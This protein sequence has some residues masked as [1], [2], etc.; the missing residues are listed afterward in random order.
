VRSTN[1]GGTDYHDIETLADIV[2]AYTGADRNL[3]RYDEDQEVLTTRSKDDR[4]QPAPNG[5]SIIVR[6]VRT[7]RRA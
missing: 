1:I 5:S 2:W 7:Q 4:H 3:V 6:R